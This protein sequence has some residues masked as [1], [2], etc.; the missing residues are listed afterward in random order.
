LFPHASGQWAKKIRGKLHYFGV[1]A[2]PDAALK[3]YS[4]QKND[5]HTGRKP[6]VETEGTTVK[7]VVNSFLSAKQALVDSGELASLT[8]RDYKTACDEIIAAFGKSR[9]AADLRPTT[10]H[11]CGSEWRRSGDR[12]GYPRPSS[13]SAAFSST[14]TMPS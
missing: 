14:A 2:D 8:W 10:S 13:S 1:W 11:A 9:L 5:L 4:E 6:R 3:S 12:S 7:Q